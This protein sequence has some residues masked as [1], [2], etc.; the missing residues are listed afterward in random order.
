[1]NSTLW[2]VENPLSIEPNRL[3]TIGSGYKVIDLR[4]VA[5]TTICLISYFRL[6][7]CRYDSLKDWLKHV[8]SLLSKY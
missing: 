7:S 8:I 6:V 1:M 3:R 2:V 5:L 4:Q